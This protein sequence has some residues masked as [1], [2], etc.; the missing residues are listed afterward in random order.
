MLEG[1]LEMTRSLAS[2][3]TA[4]AQVIELLKFLDLKINQAKDL[5]GPEAIHDLRIAIR[6]FNQADPLQTLLRR[7]RQGE[8]SGLL[9]PYNAACG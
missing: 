4:A 6:R 1:P 9:A 8:V 5:H 3:H 7:H 2:P